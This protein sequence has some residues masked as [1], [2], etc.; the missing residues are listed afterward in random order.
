MGGSRVPL[1]PAQPSQQH[2]PG[3]PASPLG[4]PWFPHTATCAACWAA[5]PDK[6]AA[7]TVAALPNQCDNANNEVGR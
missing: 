7:D 6:G 5:P 4:V 2:S 3:G 1:T